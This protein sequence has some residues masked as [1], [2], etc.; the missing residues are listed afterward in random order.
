MIEASQKMIRVNNSDS[1]E[2]ES[3]IMRINPA[4]ERH[5][6]LEI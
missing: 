5:F 3:E 1:Q 4:M 6:E 2:E